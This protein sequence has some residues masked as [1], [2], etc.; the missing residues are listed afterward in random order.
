MFVGGIDD[1]ESNVLMPSAFVE[2]VDELR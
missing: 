1:D 2:E